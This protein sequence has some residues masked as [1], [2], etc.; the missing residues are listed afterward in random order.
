MDPLLAEIR[1]FA[2]N[3]TPRGWASC[4]GQL[5][6]ISQNAAL[7]S[8]LGNTYGGDGRTTFALPKLESVPLAGLR[9]IIATEGVYPS[10]E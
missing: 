8:L 6:P 4:E 1:L 7:F 10:R 3:F 2:G 9:Y 5:L